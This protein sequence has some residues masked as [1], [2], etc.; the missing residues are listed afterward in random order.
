M[1][2]LQQEGHEAPEGHEELLLF[3]ST[4]SEGQS[5]TIS[6]VLLRD[7]AFVVKGQRCSAE[8]G[9]L[10]ALCASAVEGAGGVGKRARNNQRLL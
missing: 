9:A 3:N 6:L 5:H 10:Y 4:P 2:E 7:L 8:T 1:A